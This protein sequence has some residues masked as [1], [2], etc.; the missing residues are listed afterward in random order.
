MHPLRMLMLQLS[1]MHG[2]LLGAQ[3]EL[4]TLGVLVADSQVVDRVVEEARVVEESRVMQEARNQAATTTH[5]QL[6]NQM[7][8]LTQ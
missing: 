5:F 6:F 2:N 4:P 3:V 7:A 1:K 8:N